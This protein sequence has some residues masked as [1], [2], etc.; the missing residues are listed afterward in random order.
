MTTASASQALNPRVSRKTRLL[1]LIAGVTDRHGRFLFTLG[2]RTSV[3]VSQPS[4]RLLTLPARRRGLGIPARGAICRWETRSTTVGCEDFR[5]AVRD[6]TPQ[7]QNC[8]G[9][10][11]RPVSRAVPRD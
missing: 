2:E 11:A 4:E 6:V 5:P 8:C 1:T 9:D 7:A 3:N 10:A